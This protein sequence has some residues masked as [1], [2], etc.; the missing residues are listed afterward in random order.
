MIF[1]K[2]DFCE[3]E[4]N[5]VDVKRNEAEAKLQSCD[6][7]D[8][9]EKCWLGF[10]CAYCNNLFID[11]GGE[12]GSYFMNGEKRYERPEACTSCGP[13]YYK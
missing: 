3:K 2:C 5:A 12:L 10:R 8:R 6:E 4:L 7:I 13:K 1:H 9:C 11:E